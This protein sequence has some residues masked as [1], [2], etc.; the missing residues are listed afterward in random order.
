[1]KE[2]E[3]IENFLR[4][5]KKKFFSDNLNYAIKNLLNPRFLGSI[6]LKKNSNPSLKNVENL[7]ANDLDL[8]LT[9]SL[10]N[11]FLNPVTK[12]LIILA[13]LFNLFWFLSIY[14]I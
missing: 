9:R 11:T 13:I 3:N 10:K 12:T 7:L 8:K 4:K 14:L 1:M 5:D 2:S 6:H